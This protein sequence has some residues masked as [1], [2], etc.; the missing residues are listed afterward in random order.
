MP[1]TW[2]IAKTC[3]SSGSRSTNCEPCQGKARG[4]PSLGTAV[5]ASLHAKFVVQDRR[6][7]MLGSKNQDPRS[8]LHNTESWLVI[9]S[10]TLARELTELFDE[11]TAL[12]HV[13]RVDLD[14]AGAH[15]HLR[16]TTEQDG[17]LQTL[18]VEPETDLGLRLWRSLLGVLIPE[19]LL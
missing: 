9:D 14:A 13:Y 15:S 18:D 5:A 2:P 11:A 12:H 6:R 17:K 19:H 10:E 3:W 4:N 8:R 16:W 1:A 7:V